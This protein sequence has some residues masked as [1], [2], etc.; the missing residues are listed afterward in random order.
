VAGGV[1]LSDRVNLNTPILIKLNLLGFPAVFAHNTDG[2]CNTQGIH[3]KDILRAAILIV[4]NNGNR[5]LVHI[6][7]G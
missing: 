6:V 2:V 5:F 4:A 3:R 7:S 1:P